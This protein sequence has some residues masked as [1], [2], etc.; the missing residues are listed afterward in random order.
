MP[1]TRAQAGPPGPVPPVPLPVPLP[2]VST[3]RMPVPPLRPVSRRDGQDVP[4]VPAGVV[5]GKDRPLQVPGRGAVGAQHLGRGEYRVRGVV[6]GELGGRVGPDG[7]FGERGRLE[8]HRALGPGIVRAGVDTGSGRAAV[9][10]FNL[11]NPGEDTPGQA[12]AGLRRTHVPGQV[13]GRDVRQG[14]RARAPGQAGARLAGCRN[15][16]SERRVSPIVCAVAHG[17]AD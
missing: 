3:G 4:H 15:F 9:I 14:Q 12:W 16:C 1:V 13:G 10:A 11:A 6:R 8:L 5:V 17:V 2:L 7:V